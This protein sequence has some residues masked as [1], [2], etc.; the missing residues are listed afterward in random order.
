MTSVLISGYYGFKNLG[1][2]LILES[3]IEQLRQ[4][5]PKIDIT[6]LSA[7]PKYTSS[8]FNV[9]SI[10]RYDIPRIWIA[11]LKA[12]LLISGGGGLFQDKTSI[13]SPIYYGLIILLAKLVKVKTLIY[14]QGLGPLNS[15][16]AKF[17][18]KSSLSMADIIT[19]RD[20]ES[21]AMANSFDLKTLLTADPVWGLS[22]L[23]TYPDNL[24][25]IQAI[26]ENYPNSKLIGVSLRTDTH[27]DQKGLLN[28][29]ESLNEILSDN[30]V[31][32]LL[33]LQKDQDYDILLEFSALL[34]KNIACEVL[35]V[36]PKDITPSY[37][38]D[39]FKEFHLVI[40]MRL[41]AL[42]LSLKCG[43]NVFG[44]SYDPK[45]TALLKQLNLPF[46]LIPDLSRVNMKDTLK[47]AI[48]KPQLDLY[49]SYL[50]KFKENCNLNKNQ[51]ERL[52]D[53]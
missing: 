50:V 33:P 14:A 41:H 46:I 8:V 9:D 31:I 11:L 4:I 16:W 42:I 21:V 51:L 13:K 47:S 12:K 15:W 7:D 39:I 19:L 32:V 6:V 52:I 24:S 48:D 53:A 40:A 38:L 34:N 30:F 23:Q 27:L 2:E 25:N 20:F 22:K 44:L 1:D 29:A 17:I 36:Y 5:N 43:I 37:Y 28:L 49:K 45:V 18:T 26:K 3:L 35:T 10:N